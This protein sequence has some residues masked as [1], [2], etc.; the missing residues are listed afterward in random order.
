MKEKQ[1]SAEWKC[2]KCDEFVVKNKKELLLHLLDFHEKMDTKGFSNSQIK[3]FE[4]KFENM[5]KS[6]N[7]FPFHKSIPIFEYKEQKWRI[8]E[9]VEFQE[10]QKFS[11]MSFNV[12]F[13]LYDKDLIYTSKRIPLFIKNLIEI[14][15][16]IVG[17]QEVTKPFLDELLS[18]KWIQKTYYCS[19]D[20]LG[21]TI[22][23]FGQLILTKYPLKELKIFKFSPY[24]N[25]LMG[26]LEIG[27][28]QHVSISV[29]H[30]TSDKT[31]DYE[32]KRFN[33]IKDLT[34]FTKDFENQFILGDFNYGDNETKNDDL[35]KSFED[36]WKLLNPESPGFTFDPETN[37]LANITSLK[38]KQR[39]LDKIM[40]KSKNLKLNDIN[41]I[42]KEKIDDKYF[43]S[44][45]FGLLAEFSI[46]E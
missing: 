17:L 10:I 5:F 34:E 13:D 26:N 32:T 3:S 6:S 41:I 7:G 12:L 19:E 14:S 22:N 27:K 37:D 42:F 44:D 11:V 21:K 24:K 45:H 40:F 46:K 30:L 25:F 18:D 29:I 2:L 15:P 4:K 33:Q 1:K 9:K 23:P 38:K 31:P 36:S 35:L 8:V 16:D 39:R 20:G 43:L 28:N